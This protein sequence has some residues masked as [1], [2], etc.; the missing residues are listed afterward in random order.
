MK[1]DLHVHPPPD[2]GHQTIEEIIDRCR[3]LDI[4]VLAITDHND[5]G[6]CE[7][8]EFLAQG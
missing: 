6:G 7:E 5:K 1:A 3:Q 8:A 4:R 2:D